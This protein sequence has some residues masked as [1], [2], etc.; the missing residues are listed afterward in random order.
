MGKKTKYESKI[1][2]IEKDK[3]EE[4]RKAATTEFYLHSRGHATMALSKLHGSGFDSVTVFEQLSRSVD[5]VL[6]NDTN[7][8][9]AMLMTQAKSLEYVFYDALT[10]LPD[11]SMERAEVCASIAL[12]AQ[13]GCR[14]TLMALAELK[15]PRRTTTI[16]KQQNN[17]V[18]QQVNNNVKSELCE[19]ENNKKI[20][21]ELNVKVAYET[22]VMDIGTTIATGTANTAAETMEIL[23]GS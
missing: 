19:I 20:A 15:H 4:K 14:K 9:E 8:I 18:T 10:K 11:S 12:K 22:K 7:E 23:D 16:I 2:K 1:D 21:N 13:A 3:I 5:R 17:A 6:N